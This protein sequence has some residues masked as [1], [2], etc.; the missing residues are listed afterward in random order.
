MSATTEKAPVIVKLAP[1]ELSANHENNISRSH[2]PEERK[3]EIV[4]RAQSIIAHGQR[5]PIRAYRHKGKVEVY[6]GFTRHAAGV[7]IVN[8]F[9]YQ[10]S[11]G[12]GGVVEK[13]V[14]PN[15]DFKLDVII[16][17]IS[18]EDAEIANV[19]DNIQVNALS[20]IDIGRVAKE[21]KERRGLTDAQI[22][23]KLRITDPNKVSNCRRLL[24]LPTEVTDA[25][26]TGN[27][28]TDA[29]LKA[30]KATGAAGTEARKFLKEQVAAGKFPTATQVKKVINDNTP[31]EEAAAQGEAAATV[32]PGA[33]APRYQ[34]PGLAEVRS[35][36]KVLSEE[37]GGD[38]TLPEQ[39][40]DVIGP[41]HRWLA[42]DIQEKTLTKKL[43]EAFGVKA[44][45]K[46]PAKPRKA[47]AEKNPKDGE[48]VLDQPKEEVA[49]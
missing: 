41:I 37:L 40:L 34:P 38:D 13:V 24:A 2:T 12:K 7:L 19:V 27:L 43:D 18:P 46:A 31:P 44:A 21:L 11:D 22:T 33:N 8:G 20:D 30:V 16:D 29:G 10:E 1:S 28:S 35:Y 9:P 17:D 32:T 25:I 15:P 26:H 42:G 5:T 47:K 23:E 49:A 3:A 14:G 48:V 39:Y 45:P 36:F 6:Q 4:Q